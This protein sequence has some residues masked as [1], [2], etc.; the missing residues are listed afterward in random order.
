MANG[1]TSRE[2]HAENLIFLILQQ[3]RKFGRRAPKHVPLCTK[4]VADAVNQGC[5]SCNLRPTIRAHASLEKKHS[6]LRPPSLPPKLR[7]PLCTSQKQEK[8][9]IHIQILAQSRLHPF[10]IRGL[11]GTH[12]AHCSIRF[13]SSLAE[14]E[15]MRPAAL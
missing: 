12:Q 13:F 4:Q 9:Q 2:P 8:Q 10:G 11:L 7:D 14:S 5:S 1:S 3:G 15:T 6:F